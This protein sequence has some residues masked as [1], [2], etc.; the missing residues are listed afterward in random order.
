MT[1]VTIIAP[2]AKP[3]EVISVAS[4]GVVNVATTAFSAL[5]SLVTGIL[6]MTT[7]LTVL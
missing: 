4:D 7:W 3:V 2:Q 6:L 5:V 1:S